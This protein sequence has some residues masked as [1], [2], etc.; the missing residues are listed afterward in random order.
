VN[1]I[2]AEESSA[3]LR[4]KERVK[5]NSQPFGENIHARK[6]LRR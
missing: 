1:K 5:L 2:Y 6:M 4:Y 3:L